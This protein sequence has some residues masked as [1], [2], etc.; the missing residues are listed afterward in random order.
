MFS[1]NRAR[2]LEHQ[3]AAGV[4]HI[5]SVQDAPRQV[6]TMTDRDVSNANN[7][8][9]ESNEKNNASAAKLGHLPFVLHRSH[10][11]NGLVDQRRARRAVPIGL[12]SM[13]W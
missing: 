8:V 13:A 12:S 6:R 10:P 1:R 9:D 4:D 2:L 3:V 5:R 7:K 11:L